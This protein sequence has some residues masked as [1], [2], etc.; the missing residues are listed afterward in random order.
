M[1]MGKFMDPSHLHFSIWNH[2]PMYITNCSD[3]IPRN[4]IILHFC[5]A[6]VVSAKFVAVDSEIGPK[7][8][9]CCSVKV[10]LFYTLCCKY[11][12]AGNL[13]SWLLFTSEDQLC[14]NLHWC[15]IRDQLWLP[16]IVRLEKPVLGNNAV[17]GDN[18]QMSHRWLFSM[19]L[20]V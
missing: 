12:V 8:D 18:D 1:L 2:N 4:L 14:S 6:V 15:D 16:H 11:W 20:Y 10:R 3:S 5:T 19:D 13:Y 7:L 9:F 17:Q